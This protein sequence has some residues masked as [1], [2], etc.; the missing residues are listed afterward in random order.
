M[1]KEFGG[2]IPKGS[3]D[4]LFQKQLKL[5]VGGVPSNCTNQQLRTYFLNFGPISQARIV[6]KNRE[7]SAGYA[8]IYTDHQTAEAILRA[9]HY[10]GTGML[11]C[12]YALAKEDFNQARDDEMKRRVFVNQLPLNITEPEFFNF[13]CEWGPIEKAYLVRNKEDGSFK[14]FGFVIF[15]FQSDL[16]NLIGLNPVLVFKDKT[17]RVQ[18]AMDRK[19]QIE[20]KKEYGLQ[21]SYLYNKE[22]P[23][24]TIAKQSKAEDPKRP[25]LSVKVDH[26]PSDLRFNISENQEEYARFDS[27]LA[28]LKHNQAIEQV[29]TDSKAG[30]S[31]HSGVPFKATPNQTQSRVRFQLK[32]SK[33]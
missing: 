1:E 33:Q 23:P 10:M 18:M 15:R 9:P 19:T 4:Y 12:K 32:G 2:Y 6:N 13:F 27:R 17:I 31:N 3:R 14:P 21:P 28:L 20:Y 11:N 26:K 30:A 24:S 7:G 25:W 5:F 29:G 8:Y 22:Y 16:A